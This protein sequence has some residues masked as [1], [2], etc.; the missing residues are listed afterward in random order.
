MSHPGRPTD[1][2]V[3]AYHDAHPRP[4]LP[5]PEEVA[6]EMCDG[7]SLVMITPQRATAIIA[8]D[9]AARDA[10]HAAD[11]ARAVDAALARV[12]GIME[13]RSRQA[14]DVPVWVKQAVAALRRELAR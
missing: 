10:A 11:R 5:T 6:R 13:Q 8:A 14:F 4:A 7:Q 9:R 3:D 12:E 1:D 2:E